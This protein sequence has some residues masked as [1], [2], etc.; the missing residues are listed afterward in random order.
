MIDWINRKHISTNAIVVILMAA[1]LTAGQTVSAFADQEAAETVSGAFGRTSAEA[2]ATVK[3]PRR[4]WMTSDTLTGDWS[5]FRPWLKDHGITIKPR[6]TQFAQGIASFEENNFQYGGKAD[7]WVDF[8]LTK[9]GLWK[10]FSLTAHAEFNFCQSVNGQGGTMVPVNAAL[11]FPGMEGA[12][13]FDLSSVYLTQKFGDYV[14]LMFG[15]INMID[16]ASTKPF[17]GGAG[18]DSYWNTTFVAPPSGTVPPYLFGGLMGIKAGPVNIGI[19]IYDPNSVVN[20]TGFEDP[21]GEGVTFRGSIEVGFKIAGLT[22]HQGLVGL[23]STKNGT[24]L[25]TLD[26]L[27]LPPT[28]PGTIGIKNDRYY[29]AYTFDQ[30]FYQSKT[31]S[32][33]GVGMF[34]QFGISDGNPNKLYWSVLAGVSGTG[35]IPGRSLDNWGFGYYYDS[36]SPYIKDSLEPF[37][38][39][40]DEQGWEIFYNLSV[41]PW[42]T[43]G[44]DMQIILPC[45]SN[46]TAFFYG[47]RM[48]LRL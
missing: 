11:Q 44:A 29:F 48:V 17:M 21:F 32:S 41:T 6:L 27:Y 23:Y 28:P 37:M 19:W 9:L 18:I 43:I 4:D 46:D 8:Y 35:L 10:G 30:Y 7:L 25:E 1:A 38:E 40:R 39:I 15:K 5:G 45:M 47:L 26:D 12:E 36:L 20:K 33:E 2:S 22:G 16:I 42:F 14:S 31:N 34:G 13:A 3:P 24:D